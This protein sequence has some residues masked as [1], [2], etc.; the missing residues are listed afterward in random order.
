MLVPD[1]S[2][3]KWQSMFASGTRPAKSTATPTAR[4]YR[5][6]GCDRV[7]PALA[8]ALALALAIAIALE[9]AALVSEQGCRNVNDTPF[10]GV[11]NILYP[12]GE[13]LP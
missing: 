13:R 3:G 11:G 5:P 1:S 2:L 10:V 8:L 4:V 12:A 7:A 6:C 9:S